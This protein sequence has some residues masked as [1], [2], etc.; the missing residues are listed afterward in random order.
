MTN[1]VNIAQ[2]ANSTYSFKN[3]IING[4]MRIDQRASGASSTPTN[5]GYYTVDRWYF[6]NTLSGS[7][8]PLKI[9]Q[10]LNSVTPPAGYSNYLGLQVNTTYTPGSTDRTFIAQVIE[11]NNFYDLAWGTSN[12]KTITLSFWVYS[13]LTGT[14]GGN[15]ESENGT[16]YRSYPFTYTITSANT[17][18]Y[19]TLTIVG[20]GSAG[21]GDWVGATNNGA[22]QVMFTLSA[23]STFQGTPNTWQTADLRAPTGAT[24]LL[25]T[26]SAT[27]YITGVQLEVGTQAT[28]F[29]L[30]DY[31]KELLMCQRY[32]Y[33][34]SAYNGQNNTIDT[35]V[36]SSATTGVW[37]IKL[38]VQARVT[39][40]GIVSSANWAMNNCGPGGGGANWAAS[41]IGATQYSVYVTNGGAGSNMTA[42]YVGWVYAYSGTATLYTTGSEL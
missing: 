35:F 32:C 9:G 42:G 39:P 33:A 13:S 24:N 22:C 5:S 40:T 36:A 8:A 4:D 2:A 19:V 30:R 10:N 27:W 16:S 28:A 18:Q 21:S 12:A 3:R 31:G 38:P 6:G 26:A 11:G 29:D 23:G 41:F 7:G 14:F 15:I 20:D 1:A 34:I 17:W 37:I 25:A